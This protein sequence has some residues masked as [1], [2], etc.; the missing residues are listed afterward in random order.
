MSSRPDAY[1]FEDRFRYPP[2]DRQTIESGAAEPADPP[3]DSESVRPSGFAEWFGLSQTLLPALLFLPGSQAYRL[4][5]RVGAYAI[6][7][8][9]FAMWWFH[10]AG[11][12]QGDHPAERYLLLVLFVLVLSILHPLTNSLE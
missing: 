3:I 7:L 1:G 9:A 5:I 10:R 8:Y 4:P 12:K 2:V 11:R 6:S